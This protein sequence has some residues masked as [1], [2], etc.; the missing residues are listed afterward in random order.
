MH[1]SAVAAL[2]LLPLA[3]TSPILAARACSTPSDFFIT[4]FFTFTPAPG[5]TAGGASIS[6]RLSDSATNIS[7]SCERSLAPG[8]GQSIA[9]PDHY[10]A[11]GNPAV[12]FLYDGTVLAVKENFNCNG[13]VELLSLTDDLFRTVA[14]NHWQSLLIITSEPSD[15]PKPH[16]ATPRLEPSAS[17]S[18]LPSQ[19]ALAPSA[20]HPPGPLISSSVASNELRVVEM[21][22]ECGEM[23][24]GLG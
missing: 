1:L 3:L 9:D 6:F 17:P 13:Y 18:S 24:G 23:N 19:E 2:A 4:G 21:E 5:N 7:T 11:C 8:S 14:L 10:Y 22:G 16:P 20:R 12:T 15:N